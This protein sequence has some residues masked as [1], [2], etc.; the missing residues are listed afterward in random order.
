MLREIKYTIFFR[1]KQSFLIYKKNTIFA[2]L[3]IKKLDN[4]ARIAC[5]FL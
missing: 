1:K 2:Q 5:L 3:F 4:G